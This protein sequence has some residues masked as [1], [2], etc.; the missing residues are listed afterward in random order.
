MNI[1]I[2]LASLVAFSLAWSGSAMA[3]AFT[4]DAGFYVGASVGSASVEVSDSGAT[5]DEDDFAWKIFGGYQLNGWLAVEGGYVDFGA[6]DDSAQGIEVDPWGL[7]AFAVAGIP[8]GPVR[9][10]GKLGAVYY[11]A[12]VDISGFES[13]DEDGVEIAAGVGAEIE[14][15]SLGV[16]AEIEYFDIEDDI[17]MYSL[18]ATFTF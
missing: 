2:V 3:D 7:D 9:L 17:L 14:L 5:F 11:N 13:F 12:D 10:F 8:L 1:K 15:F 18:G 4:K 16:R 6:P